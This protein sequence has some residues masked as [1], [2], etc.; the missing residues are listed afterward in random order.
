MLDV[1][2][3]LER[4]GGDASARDAAPLEAERR[5]IE[6]GVGS[7]MRA[8]LVAGD[9]KEFERLLGA[10]SNVCCIVDPA[11][12]DEDEDDEA[13]RKRECEDDAAEE[14]RVP[15]REPAKVASAG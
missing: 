12:E 15:V 1:V 14:Q 2:D 5:L 8:A 7:A 10:K 6:A 11:L 13:R 9:R 4:L 3:F